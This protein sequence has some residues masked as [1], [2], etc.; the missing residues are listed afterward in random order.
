[1]KKHEEIHKD[2]NCLEN[3]SRRSVM[4]KALYNTPKLLLLGA[5]VATGPQ[6]VAA[7]T[8]E[9]GTPGCPPCPPEGQQQVS[10]D[11]NH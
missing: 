2:N 11:R 3:E 9:C 1:M 5:M 4:K 8:C 10:N 6:A 7:S